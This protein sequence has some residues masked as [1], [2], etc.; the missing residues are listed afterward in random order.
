VYDERTVTIYRA[1]PPEIAE[2]AVHTGSLAGAA[3]GRYLDEWITGITDVTA[4]AHEIRE[5]VRAGR[6]ATAR[7]PAEM[8]YQS[9]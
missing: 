9:C 3:V 7:L 1:Y 4:L 6:D 8:P 5:L 2:P